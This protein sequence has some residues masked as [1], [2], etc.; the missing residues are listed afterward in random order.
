MTESNVPPPPPPPSEPGSSLPYQTPGGG[1]GYPGPYVGPEPSKDDIELT[2][3]L[4]AAGVIMGIF[5][6]DHVILGDGQYCS[7]REKGYLGLG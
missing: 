6:I 1:S 4:V 5:V 2:A 3:R 7:F